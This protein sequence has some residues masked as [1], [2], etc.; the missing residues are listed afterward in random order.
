MKPPLII[1]N[2][3]MKPESPADVRDILA[4]A[5]ETLGELGDRKEY[6]L[7]FCPPF[8]FLDEVRELIRQ[9]HLLHDAELGAQDI[10]VSDD[11]VLTGEVSGPQLVGSG[12]RYVIVGHSERRYAL[13]EDDATVNAKLKTVLRNGLVPIVCVGERSR[14]DGWHEELKEQVGATF[15]GLD[16]PALDRCI[17]AYEPVWAISTNPGAQPDSPESAAASI[18]FVEGLLKE[19]GASPVLVYGGSVNPANIAS[20]LGAEGIRGVLIGGA[21]VRPDDYAAIL[22]EVALIP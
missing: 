3:K 13:G 21:S 2:W 1:S 6:S 11:A 17:V 18:A 10:A 20:F 14:S 7:V 16:A 4:R 19:K 5:D 8:V 15:A 12:V 22:R 9:S